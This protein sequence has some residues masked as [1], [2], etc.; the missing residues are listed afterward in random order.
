MHVPVERA[1]GLEAVKTKLAAT[2]RRRERRQLLEA[3]VVPLARRGDPGALELLTD[4]ARDPRS[5]VREEAIRGLSASGRAA[6]PCIRALIEAEVVDPA[7]PWALGMVGSAEDAELL[8][9]FLH[10]R[11]LRLRYTAT[12]ALDDLAVPASH[13]GFRL[14]LRDKRLFVRARAMAAL[15]ERCSDLELVEALDAAKYDVPWYRLL[16]RRY[17]SLWARGPRARAWRGRRPR[18]D[19]E[20]RHAPD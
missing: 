17:F 7:L 18:A 10:R 11:G 9:S 20:A 8:L 16:T 3:E 15:R 1:H 19:E 2:R 13:E 12:E 4:L 6:V 5:G 14:A